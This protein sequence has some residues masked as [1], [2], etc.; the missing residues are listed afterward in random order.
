MTMWWLPVRGSCT[1]SWDVLV[2][3]QNAGL[4]RL[5]VPWCLQLQADRCQRPSLTTERML[6][7]AGWQFTWWVPL[8]YLD[9]VGVHSAWTRVWRRQYRQ[10]EW[11][12]CCQHA[13]PGEAGYRLR[14]DGDGRRVT[15][16]H[17]QQDC[18][19]RRTA[20][21]LVLSPEVCQLPAWSPSTCA[22]ELPMF[23]QVRL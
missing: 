8:I 3:R 20:E 12:L 19:T 11:T 7:V 6:P 23:W 16:W 1:T 4:E 13:S 15:L 9:S 17:R 22:D 10:W 18:S 5:Q 21:V 2:K 14:T